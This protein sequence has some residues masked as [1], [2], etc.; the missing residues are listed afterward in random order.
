MP[1]PG[2]LHPEPLL[3][4]QDAAGLD[5]H[6]RLPDSVLSQSLWDLWVLVHTRFVLA[7]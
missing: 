6:R 1:Y 7:L 2:V 4:R 5:L 3:L